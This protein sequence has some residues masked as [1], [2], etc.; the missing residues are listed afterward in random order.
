[1]ATGSPL[2]SSSKHKLPDT[3]AVALHTASAAYRTGDLR[4]ARAAV[5]DDLGRWIP[6]VPITF[7]L[8][9]I[10]PPV[11][12][13]VEDVKSALTRSKVIS[14]SRWK[15]FAKD[16]ADTFTVENKTFTPLADLFSQICNSVPTDR[17]DVDLEEGDGDQQ[18]KRTGKGRKKGKSKGKEKEKA[19]GCGTEDATS[20]V[21]PYVRFVNNPDGAPFS[22]RSNETRPDGYFVRDST[23]TGRPLPR[24]STKSAAPLHHWYDIPLSSEYK[25]HT[26]VVDIG[27]V[28]FQNVIER[29]SAR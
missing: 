7:M 15:A 17:N 16:P 1:M 12:F 24:E 8:D 25:K 27:D 19:T 3:P 4:S 10:I 18:E 5:L 29:V 22:E 2:P 11:K 14:G 9:Y 6:E 28:G 26:T 21:S 13:D 20:Q 23:Y